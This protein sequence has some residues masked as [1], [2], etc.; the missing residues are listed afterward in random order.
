MTGF[1]KCFAAN[2]A[3]R[4]T[5][6]F[7]RL[8]WRHL[9]ISSVGGTVINNL[10]FCDAAADTVTQSFRTRCLFFSEDLGNAELPPAESIA[11]ICFPRRRGRGATFTTWADVRAMY[12]DLLFL[13]VLPFL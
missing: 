12:T 6:I 7:L 2:I 4:S 11:R 8:Q 5:C 10:A 3:W 9:G 1:G 13:G